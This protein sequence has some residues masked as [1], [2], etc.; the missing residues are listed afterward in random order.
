M[1][2]TIG[3]ISHRPA[4]AVF[5]AQVFREL[6]GDEAEIVT[7]ATEDGS[8][9]SMK[10]ADLYVSSVTGYDVLQDNR[11]KEYVNEELHPIR[12][13]VT[14]SKAAVDLLRTYPEGT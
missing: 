11:I 10:K 8:V 1:K 9:R 4:M 2:K 3:I 14:F 12:M 5:Y 13:D 7:G 6:F